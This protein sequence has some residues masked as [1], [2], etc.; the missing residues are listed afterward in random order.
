[1]VIVVQ[2]V[3]TGGNGLVAVWD[4]PGHCSL[5]PSC[6]S[7][8]FW[9]KKLKRKKKS[10]LAPMWRM[11]ERH[12]SRSSKRLVG[13]GTEVEVER[14]RG[15]K[16][17]FRS[18]TGPLNRV[19]AAGARGGASGT[20][21]GEGITQK[22]LAL[23]TGGMMVMFYCFYSGEKKSLGEKVPT[24]CHFKITNLNKHIGNN[25]SL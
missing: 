11:D 2:H 13:L 19:D 7:L 18:W 16:M 14:N 1:M 12:C 25:V 4:L 20:R 9:K 23:A 22:F 15:F 8:R 17:Y 24:S 10:I 6:R 3:T 5:Q 21:M